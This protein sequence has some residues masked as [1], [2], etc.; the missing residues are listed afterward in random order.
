MGGQGLGSEGKGGRGSCVE[1][2]WRVV[3]AG[4][5]GAAGSSIAPPPLG[6]ATACENIPAPKEKFG[7]GLEL[8]FE[9]DWDRAEGS[10]RQRRVAR[11]RAL[12]PGG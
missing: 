2:G 11:P 1:T 10:Q 8:K 7:L 6:K 12:A 3:L 9:T 4:P 5:P